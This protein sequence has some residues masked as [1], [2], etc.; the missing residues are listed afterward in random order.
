M[1]A[2][3]NPEIFKET[4]ANSFHCVTTAMQSALI[5]C[6]IHACQNCCCHLVW[7]LEVSRSGWTEW[8]VFLKLAGKIETTNFQV[9]FIFG[10]VG[11]N[12]GRI[13]HARWQSPILPLHAVLTHV[14]LSWHPLLRGS[15]IKVNIIAWLHPPERYVEIVTPSTCKIIIFRIRYRTFADGIKIR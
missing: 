3:G 6:L 10:W 5:C 11:G 8:V 7:K 1:W 14:N 2:N 15:Y 12:V 4:T 13:G 9:S